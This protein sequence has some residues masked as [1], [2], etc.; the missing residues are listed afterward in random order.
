MTKRFESLDVL[1]GLTVT[2]MCMVNNPGT[3]A[4]MYPPMKHASWVGCTPTDLIYPFFIFCAGCAMAFS[5]SKFDSFSGKAFMKLLKRSIGIFMVGLLLNLYPFYPTSPHCEDWT[6]W[7]NWTYWLSNKRIMGVLQRIALSY[8]IA[9][10]LALWLRKPKKVM[11]AIAALCVAYTAILVIWGTDP[12]PFTLEGTVSRRI[13]VALLGDSH[14]YHGYRFDDG[15]R[16]AFDPEGPLGAMTGAC[17]CLLGYL[18][19]SLIIGSTRRLAADPASVKDQPA[20]MVCRIFLAGMLSLGFAEILSIWIPISKPLWSVSYVFYAGGWAMIALAAFTFVI[21][22]CG[23]AKPFK[24]FKIMGMNALMAFVL[25][26]VIAK[27]YQFV[28]WSS[29][30]YFGANEFTSF[31]YSC[32]FALVIFLILWALYARKI[33]IRL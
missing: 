28:G 5:Y 15:T 4:H 27:S 11:I 20:Y 6:F 2:F 29:A 16:A 19:G 31:C 3:W 21:D 7:Q 33:F 32:I 26:G 12:G 9:G 13:D 23:I 17:T 1:R 25:S 30:K 10:V 8:F 18:I 14:V 22:V 24:G